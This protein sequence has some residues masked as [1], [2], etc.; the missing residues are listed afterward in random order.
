[1][2]YGIEKNEADLADRMR[3]FEV[4]CK[5]AFQTDAARYYSSGTGERISLYKI[6]EEHFGLN[7]HQS[8]KCIGRAQ[9]MLAD[10]SNSVSSETLLVAERKRQA[11][12]ALKAA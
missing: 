11:R 2:I 9:N 5:V 7:N 8:R 3:Q 12:M 1:M 6:A 4:V 10:V